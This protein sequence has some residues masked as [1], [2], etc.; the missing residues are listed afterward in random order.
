[1][2]VFLTPSE[3]IGALAS[4]AWSV[5]IWIAAGLLVFAGALTFGELA[6]RH[7]RSG[8]LYVYLREAFG[9]RTAFLYGW[10][11]LLV[12]D[13]GI[14]ASIALGASGYVAVLFPSAAGHEKAI[15]IA[16][17]WILAAANMTGLRLGARL[18]NG[19]TVI[20][21][22]AIAGIAAVAFL[23]GGGSATHFVPFFARRSDAPPI[24]QA[25]GLGLVA[26]FFSFGGF[27]EASRVAGEV[28]DPEKT[29]P[30][31]LGLGVAVVTLAYAAT[32]AAFLYL[33]P[34][35]AAKSAAD[36][37]RQAGEAMLGR[38]GPAVLSAVVVV[39]VVVS[40]LAFFLMAPRLY[41]AMARDGL[42]PAALAAPN[43]RGAPAR[44]TAV[45]AAAATLLIASGSFSEIVAYFLCPALVFIALSAAAL[46]VLRRRRPA[47]P[48]AV[49]GYP[50][51]P[52]LFVVFLGLVVAAIAA[53]RPARAAA[54][55]A[56]TVAGLPVYEI[57][58]TRRENAAPEARAER[59]EGR[60]SGE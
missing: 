47:S 54:G 11:A 60:A 1:V 14:A 52:V 15:A 32:T 13:P 8:G 19:L 39:S 10:Q 22:A 33:V 28:R 46:F 20:K 4:P 44:A 42:L 53:A 31:A 27:W 48:F 18:L 37:A 7:P 9:P 43:S 35:G 25:L 26:V 40:A 2:G 49:P 50:A 41:V 56:L 38:G 58:R 16:M 17:I 6:A 21:V 59:G 45:L 3:L 55:V 12:M 34:F 30:R 51:T 5:G 29:L 23:S 36:L 57:L 24:G